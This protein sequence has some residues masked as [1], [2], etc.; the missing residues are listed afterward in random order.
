MNKEKKER[1]NKIYREY[2]KGRSSLRAIAKENN[3]S[4]I[5]VRQIIIYVKQ[6]YGR[7]NTKT[8]TSG[9]NINRP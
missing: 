5:R 4:H 2:K 9:S 3:I 6:K 7:I 1:N 8:I